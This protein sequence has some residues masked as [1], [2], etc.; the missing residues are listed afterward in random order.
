[1]SKTAEEDITEPCTPEG[2][3]E[4]AY[5]A[6]NRSEGMSISQAIRLKNMI[7]QAMQQMA[8]E[9]AEWVAPYNYYGKGIWVGFDNVQYSTPDL[10]QL[11]LTHQNQK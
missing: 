10:Y 3:S 1:M 7:E 11:F 6:A 9:F 5:T 2:I 8:V 4:W